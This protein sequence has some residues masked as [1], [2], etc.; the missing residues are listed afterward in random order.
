MRFIKRLM[1]IKEE[2]LKLEL[3]R[4]NVLSHIRLDIE[5]ILKLM[6]GGRDGKDKNK[7][8]RCKVRKTKR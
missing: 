8:N 2:Q 6:K 1:E 7:C 5:E 3:K 4:L